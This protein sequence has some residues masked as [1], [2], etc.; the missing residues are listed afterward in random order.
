MCQEF[1]LAQFQKRDITVCTYIL[2]KAPG[3]R[4]YKGKLICIIRSE[5][6]VSLKDKDRSPGKLE[7]VKYLGRWK[8][9][10]W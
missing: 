8:Q 5:V 6:C 7:D 2:R 4:W 9:V 10:T 1:L 3:H